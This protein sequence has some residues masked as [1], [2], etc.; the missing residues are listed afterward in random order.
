MLHRAQAND[1][2]WHGLFGGLYLPHLR[3][4]I[5]N[6]LLALENAIAAVSPRPPVERADL[7]CD[8]HDEL[9]LC[10]ETLQA[11]VRA[12]GDAA[13]I[14]L[15]SFALAHNFGDTLR[16]Y[17]EGYH[18][19]LHVT[20]SG[21]AQHGGIASAH[22]RVAFRHVIHPEDAE[23]DSRPRA[24]F[25]DCWHADEGEPQPL[26]D[27]HEIETATFSATI[28]SSQIVKSYRVTESGLR[29]RYQL[30]RPAKGVTGHLEIRL[31]LAMPSC[32][33]YLGRYILED[34][35]IP[36][37]F[38]EP[39]NLAALGRLQ[40]DDGVLGGSLSIEASQP[41][42]FTAK[43]HRTVSQ[44]EAGFEKIM[45]AVELAFFWP[46]DGKAQELIFAIAARK[47]AA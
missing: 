8:G 39:L 13:L 27:Y 44:S 4:A 12:D 10:G 5:W 15:S 42:P 19:K 11:V 46:L 6:N 1:A 43:A 45:Q 3:R 40:L 32:D 26:C 20:N 22:D 30:Q 2:Y 25:M 24:M 47:R 31:N 35:S 33:G 37:G 23:P 29:V 21:Q 28:G 14:E 16:R 9:F 36:G 38:G 17:D 41:V 7:D 34:G 18:D